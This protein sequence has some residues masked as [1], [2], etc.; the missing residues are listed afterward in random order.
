MS[1][2][3]LHDAVD[4][5]RLRVQPLAHYRYPVLHLLLAVVLLGTLAAGGAISA[6]ATGDPAT[7]V[8]FFTLYVALETL[9]FGQFMRWW[10]TRGGAVVEMPLFGLIIAASGMQVLDPLTF[11]L[12]DDVANGLSLV[13]GVANI[14]ILIRAL[15]LST[16]TSR[17]RVLLGI[18]LFS[19]V[20][21]VLLLTLLSLGSDMGLA[22]NVPTLNTP[23]P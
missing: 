22:L 12:P 13:F 8:V 20:A 5:I 7:M 2:P 23:A 11:W 21:L 17:G 3:L 19:P 1:A 16:G 15:A 18:L 4:L 9:L 6:G 14:M 10:L